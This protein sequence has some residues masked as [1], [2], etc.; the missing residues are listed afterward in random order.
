MSLILCPCFDNVNVGRVTTLVTRVDDQ[1]KAAP[2]QTRR[3][4]VYLNRLGF[5]NRRHGARLGRPLNCGEERLMIGGQGVISA[6]G[7]HARFGARSR[8]RHYRLTEL[9]RLDNMEERGAI[10]KRC[11]GRY[12]GWHRLESRAE[13]VTVEPP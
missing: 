6:A 7:A 9:S 3:F 8:N 12:L 2:E 11:D 1:P 5:V 13:S 4:R 10:R